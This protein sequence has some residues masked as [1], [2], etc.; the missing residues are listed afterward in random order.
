VYSCY[1]VP[2]SNYCAHAASEMYSKLSGPDPDG[3]VTIDDNRLDR[4]DL[5]RPDRGPSARRASRHVK[6]TTAFSAP[7]RRSSDASATCDSSGRREIR[8]RNGTLAAGPT[9]Q[10]PAAGFVRHEVRRS[11][12][13]TISPR[14]VAVT[15]VTTFRHLVRARDAVL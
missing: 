3:A 1:R 14:S 10:V 6:N 2:R 8:D 12:A 4:V 15:R 7:F 13:H 11:N 5:T 9:W